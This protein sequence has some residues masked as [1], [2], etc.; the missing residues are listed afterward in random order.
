VRPSLSD[1]HQNESWC[2]RIG[3]PRSGV[4]VSM[5]VGPHRTRN[6]GVFSSVKQ[7]T[8]RENLAFDRDHTHLNTEEFAEV[9]TYTPKGGG[10]RDVTAVV[11]LDISP[12]EDNFS[13][14][15]TETIFVVVS[16]KPGPRGFI[17]NPIVNDELVRAAEN[18]RAEPYR[19][20]G[21]ITDT[22]EELHTLTFQRRRTIQSGNRHVSQNL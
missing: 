15:Q 8:F 11:D 5:E 19:F 2:V 22:T 9:V 20:T 14:R 10:S 12:G 21:E 4:V 17:D 13:A 16:R 7:M 18:D 6:P 1:P 3:F